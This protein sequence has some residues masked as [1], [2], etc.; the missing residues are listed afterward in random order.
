LL[1]SA[2]LVRAGGMVSG[3]VHGMVNGL[4]HGRSVDDQP[5]IWCA[6]IVLSCRLS[7][8]RGL[9]ACTHWVRR[10][11][12]GTSDTD[13]GTDAPGLSGLARSL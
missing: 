11:G 2:P 10:V 6:A 7:G 13:C 1:T 12:V 4:L 5:A 9:G 8:Q 3:L